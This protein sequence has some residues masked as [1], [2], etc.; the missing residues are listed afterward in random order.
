M[1]KKFKWD[2]PAELARQMDCKSSWITQGVS[3]HEKLYNQL[4]NGLKVYCMIENGEIL[5]GEVEENNELKYFC[6]C[7][8]FNAKTYLLLRLAGVKKVGDLL[9]E[10]NT[11]INRNWARV[12]EF[13]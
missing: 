12:Q 11:V 13:V 10:E 6:I 5:P 1:I 3:I 9:D 2:K 4:M 7:N 8:K